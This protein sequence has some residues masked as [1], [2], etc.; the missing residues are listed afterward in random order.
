[1]LDTLVERALTLESEQPATLTELFNPPQDPTGDAFHHQFAVARLGDGMP[2]LAYARLAAPGTAP[3]PRTPQQTTAV[4]GAA[5][6]TAQPLNPG[7]LATLNAV[8]NRHHA[9]YLDAAD[10][11]TDT[12]VR[13]DAPQRIGMVGFFTPLIPP[14]LQAG[15]RIQCVELDPQHWQSTP[16]LNVSADRA[17]LSH[18][19]TVLCTATVLLNGTFESVRDAARHCTRFVLVGPSTPLAPD[20]LSHHGVTHLASR[21]VSDTEAFWAACRSGTDWSRHTT[22]YLLDIRKTPPHRCEGALD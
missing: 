4:L 2:G 14:L 10:T 5:R 6:S 9:E 1:M 16:D 8:F 18:C 17:V 22:K 20:C 3:I 21:H 13:F 11:L 12:V 15:H 19:D 7:T